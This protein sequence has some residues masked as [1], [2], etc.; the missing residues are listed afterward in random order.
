MPFHDL[1]NDEVNQ[2]SN[3]IRSG[4][5][6]RSDL[7]D[8]S[9]LNVLWCGVVLVLKNNI[10]FMGHEDISVISSQLPVHVQR[11]F[12]ALFSTFEV[13]MDHQSRNSKYLVQS[14]IVC[15]QPNAQHVQTIIIQMIKHYKS[16]FS[17]AY[18]FN[19]RTGLNPI[20]QTQQVVEYFD[21]ESDSIRP[22]SHFTTGTNQQ[23]LIEDD[24]SDSYDQLI[25][26]TTDNFSVPKFSAPSVM[27]LRPV[28]LLSDDEHYGSDYQPAAVSDRENDVLYNKNHA[29][30]SGE[31]QQHLAL[32]NDDS[33]YSIDGGSI[34]NNYYKYSGWNNTFEEDEDSG[35]DQPEQPA[36]PMP[37]TR[38]MTRM[39]QQQQQSS[40]NTKENKTKNNKR[41]PSK[42]PN[43][44]LESESTV[45]HSRDEIE[46]IGTYKSSKFH[47]GSEDKNHSSTVLNRHHYSHTHS[48]LSSDSSSEGDGNEEDESDDEPSDYSTEHLSKSQSSRGVFGH[49]TAADRPVSYRETAAVTEEVMDFEEPSF[50]DDYVPPVAAT[51]RSVGN[52]NTQSRHA[53]EPQSPSSVGS[54]IE[55]S[56][57]DK[58]AHRSTSA[59]RVNKAE[60]D[61]SSGGDR[62]GKYHHHGQEHARSKRSVL[63]DVEIAPEPVSHHQQVSSNP[64]SGVKKYR[65]P[66]DA[67]IEAP[68]GFGAGPEHRAGLANRARNP[69]D[70]SVEDWRASADGFDDDVEE[71]PPR[72]LHQKRDNSSGKNWANAGSGKYTPTVAARS[73]VRMP[74]ASPT[75]PIGNTEGTSVDLVS[76]W[77]SQ[78]SEEEPVRGANVSKWQQQD[79]SSATATKTDH[80]TQAHSNAPKQQQYQHQQESNMRNTPSPSISIPVVRSAVSQPSESAERVAEL[81]RLRA[82][83]LKKKREKELAVASPLR[84][85]A[86]EVGAESGYS[87]GQETSSSNSGVRSLMKS[88]GQPVSILRKSVTFED[89]QPL[90]GIAS[91]VTAPSPVSLPTTVPA[92]ITSAASPSVQVRAPTVSTSTIPKPMS[93]T[94]LPVASS[95]VKPPVGRVAR[96]NS[97]DLVLYGSRQSSIN[98]LEELIANDSEER[99]SSEASSEAHSPRSPS[100][101][102]YSI[103]SE[104]DT[105]AA[106]GVQLDHS[107]QPTHTAMI[108]SQLAKS[109]GEK[110]DSPVLLS[111]RPPLPSGHSSSSVGDLLSRPVLQRIPSDQ[112]LLPASQLTSSALASR[113][114]QQSS[115]TGVSMR[116]PSPDSILRQSTLSQLSSSSLS[117]HGRTVPNLTEHFQPPPLS[118]FALSSGIILEGYLHKKSSGIM[119]IWQKVLLLN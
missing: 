18:M 75:R 30:R 32:L 43:Q 57:H 17:Y 45:T 106:V 101:R 38:R 116:S 26:A 115:A 107:A 68:S 4:D 97:S 58:H 89:Q 7:D 5:A 65:N 11:F 23:L 60:D 72:S 54:S 66:L 28:K 98:N 14:L 42:K 71:N 80:T 114:T 90:L 55:L 41:K 1:K 104:T 109:V 36:L 46:D 53:L 110:Q 44:S 117:I 82:N 56:D 94:E 31:Q 20:S 24:D 19:R 95:S 13:L 96:D 77:D 15:V 86:S 76:D 27:P 91:P 25:H 113:R 62:P 112:L 35:D 16:L 47:T 40:K 79:R 78:L 59:F 93:G 29:E 105:G 99:A 69:L 10:Y 52:T 48:R 33:M 119:G 84:S 83:I 103:G 85:I 61:W 49:R 9:S 63:S 50:A 8:A 100:A 88:P 37:R 92:G 22:T 73:V 70:K 51:R 102:R 21:S 108:Q 111:N 6:S 67:S 3:I 64:T 87:S 2:L 39:R 81:E 12:G 74:S 34:L 118:E